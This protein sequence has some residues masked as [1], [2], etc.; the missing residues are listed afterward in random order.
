MSRLSVRSKAS[1]ARA[2]PPAR[3]ARS[4]RTEHALH[5]HMV[6]QEA[7]A[8]EVQRKQDLLLAPVGCQKSGCPTCHSTCREPGIRRR[9]RTT[10][11]LGRG[12]LYP[13]VRCPG[14]ALL[15]TP[16]QVYRQRD[17]S[18]RKSGVRCCQ[19]PRSARSKVE[20][21]N[22]CSVAATVGSESAAA[23][24]VQLPDGR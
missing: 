11:E 15:R 24:V 20:Q 13:R 18:G 17:A 1:P 10:L 22:L 12:P 2:R 8:A 21:S 9:S 16:L 23:Y 3:C 6:V 14:H 4:P 7:G 19:T 5:A